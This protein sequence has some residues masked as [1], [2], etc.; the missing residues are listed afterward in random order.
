MKKHYPVI[1]LPDGRRVVVDKMIKEGDWGIPQC[2]NESFNNKLIQFVKKADYMIDCIMVIDSEGNEFTTTKHLYDGGKGRVIFTIGFSLPNVPKIVL[3]EV[4]DVERLAE[5]TYPSFQEC[6]ARGARYDMTEYEFNR[7][8]Y[9]Q[10]NGFINGY[11]AANKNFTEENL[12]KA[13]DLGCQQN[14]FW[15]KSVF[16]KMFSELIQSLTLPEVSEIIVEW[17]QIVCNSASGGCYPT[18]R[19]KIKSLS[20]KN[21][22]GREIKVKVK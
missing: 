4:E 5:Q 6:K 13:W 8:C 9:S 21:K 22:D 14:P 3:E 15:E 2:V 16:D 19:F 17:E 20:A 10:R 18:G 7:T 11:K 12:R 1:P